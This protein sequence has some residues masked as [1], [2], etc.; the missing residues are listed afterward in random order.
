MKKLYFSIMLLYAAIG[1]QG[2]NILYSNNFENGVGGA[3][4]VGNGEII[5]SENSRFGRIFHNAKGGEGIRQNYLLLPNN[6]FA[7]LQT[8]STNQLTISFWINKGTATNFYWSPI[9]TAYG[10]APINNV[11]TW[12]M[13]ALQSRLLAQVNCA[14]WTNFENAQNATGKNRESTEWLDDSKWHFYA[15]TYT[16]TSVKIY[17]DGIVQN[18]WAVSQDDGKKASGIFSHGSELKYISR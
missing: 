8:T 11:N 13:L 12:P 17:I 6:I 2:Q 10:A 5:D 4:I 16:A 14:G 7:N 15:A 18:E 9:F 1:V 3:T